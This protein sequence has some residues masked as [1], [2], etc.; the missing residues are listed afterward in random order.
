MCA[1]LH[2]FEK[3]T[4]Q[5]TH[6]APNRSSRVAH[7]PR[8]HQSVPCRHDYRRAVVNALH[9]AEHAPRKLLVHVRARPQCF[10]S[11]AATFIFVRAIQGN[12]TRD[13]W[14][15]LVE[16]QLDFTEICLVLDD[17]RKLQ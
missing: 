3:E 1:D 16:A 9:W 12:V 10:D 11:G 6:T 4:K 15:V 17:L 7:M 8:V 5:P 13:K 2:A 14:P